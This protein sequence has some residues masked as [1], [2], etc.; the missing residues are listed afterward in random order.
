M[1]DN[2]LRKLKQD[3][4][5]ADAIANSATRLEPDAELEEYDDDNRQAK[6]EE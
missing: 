6:T 3:L 1:P 5:E 2:Y 4:A